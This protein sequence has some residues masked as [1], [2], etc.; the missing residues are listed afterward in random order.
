MGCSWAA[1]PRFA[2][3]STSGLS[4]L[5]WLRFSALFFSGS[6]TIIGSATWAAPVEVTAGACTHLNVLWDAQT[7]T[8]SAGSVANIHSKEKLKNHS[9]IPRG[10]NGMESPHTPVTKEGLLLKQSDYLGQWR[11]RYA[12]LTCGQTGPVLSFYSAGSATTGQ[13]EGRRVVLKGGMVTAHRVSRTTGI[14]PAFSYYPFTVETKRKTLFLATMTDDECAVWV[15]SISK[16][17]QQWEAGATHSMV[18]LDHID[19]SD[20]NNYVYILELCRPDGVPVQISCRYSTLRRLALHVRE[21]EPQAAGKLPTFPP[22]QPLKEQGTTFLVERGIAIEKYVRA[23]L[24]CPVLAQIEAV[25]AAFPMPSPAPAEPGVEDAAAVRVQA[26]QRGRM[27]RKHAAEYSAAAAKV[28][29]VQRGRMQRQQQHS[30]RKMRAPRTVRFHMRVDGLFALDLQMS[31][32]C[33][34]WS[35][36]CCSTG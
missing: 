7:G 19:V 12:R 17:I 35:S 20:G 15:Q 2:A 25:R 29:A 1:A 26:V 31:C 4:R 6:A 36:R 33:L 34:Q 23:L 32:K 9:R 21:V 30:I 14:G 3:P 22:R 13:V 11:Q 8:L 5:S 16:S 18:L 28:Q 24:A 27:E 10:R